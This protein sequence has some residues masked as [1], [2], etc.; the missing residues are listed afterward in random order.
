M[1]NNNK[2]EISFFRF[3]ALTFRGFSSREVVWGFVTTFG[4]G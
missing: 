1:K 4:T 3:L 2:D